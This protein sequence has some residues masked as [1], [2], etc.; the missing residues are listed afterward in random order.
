VKPERI[1][2]QEQ[3]PCPRCKRGN[4]QA[5]LLTEAFG[6]DRCQQIFGLSEDNQTI[7][8]LST[9]YPYTKTWQW[10]AEGWHSKDRVLGEHYIPLVLGSL[11]I[12]FFMTF[13]L[14]RNFHQILPGP[15]V[16]LYIAITFLVMTLPT[17]MLW[18]VLRD[19][20]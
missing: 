19:G 9:S 1:D 4:L 10:M 16:V 13:W 14:P 15:G 18:L 12:S 5:I 20:N 8:Q 2:L 3:Y 7:E 11:A 17:L 6:C